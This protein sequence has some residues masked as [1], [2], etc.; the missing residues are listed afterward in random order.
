MNL[1][2]AY[3]MGGEASY[4][5][6]NYPALHNSGQE[7]SNQLQQY[8]IQKVNK[9]RHNRNKMEAVQILIV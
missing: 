3:H 4:P 5:P 9:K 2:K 1:L 7:V 8:G 6:L